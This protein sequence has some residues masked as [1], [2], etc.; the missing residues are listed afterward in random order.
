MRHVILATAAA[1]LLL[2]PAGSASA[3][4]GKHTQSYTEN[5]HG[6][7]TE[8]FGPNP[9]TGAA[10]SSVQAHG[11]VVNHVTYFP[12]SDE[13][14]ATFTETGDITL[15]DANDVTYTGHFALWGNYNLNERN[16]NQTFTIA[17]RADGSDG[18]TIA[19]HE[20]THFDLN[21]NGIVTVDFDR[22]SLNCG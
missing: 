2:L 9:C 1:A 12:D 6:A 19:M 13:V 4:G 7:F 14:W 20:V 5:I 22:I 17:F 16:T 15:T 3:A 21:A 18:S 10:I 8:T 11:N